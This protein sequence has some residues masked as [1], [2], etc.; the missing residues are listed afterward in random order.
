MHVRC[1]G[2]KLSLFW[3]GSEWATD[4]GI[5]D[6][7]RVRMK[8]WCHNPVVL[9]CTIVGRVI[10]EQ[11]DYTV[12]ISFGLVAHHKFMLCRSLLGGFRTYPF[13]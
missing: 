7:T 10:G 8:F 9:C 12:E 1:E 2:P 3:T 4:C 5:C 6:E 13:L 11:R